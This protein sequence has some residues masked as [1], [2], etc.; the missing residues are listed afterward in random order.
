[1]LFIYLGQNTILLLI[2]NIRC[3][4][5]AFPGHVVQNT[6]EA[7][8]FIPCFQNYEVELAVQGVS[9]TEWSAEDSD[10]SEVEVA[11]DW[12]L[13]RASR[14]P[15]IVT[16]PPVALATTSNNSS[17]PAFYNP[18]IYAKKEGPGNQTSI[19][20]TQIGELQ[21]TLYQTNLF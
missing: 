19:S 8:C 14:P 3:D 13:Y 5:E 9:G 16:P 17:P 4:P 2:Y 11:I 21:V 15:L 7:L 6:F 10:G 12:E 18:G 20:L 1:M